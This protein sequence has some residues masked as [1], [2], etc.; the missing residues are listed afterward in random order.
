[1]L[2]PRRL[3]GRW[4]PRHQRAGRSKLCAALICRESTLTWHRVAERS[5]KRVAAL[6]SRMSKPV[7]QQDPCLRHVQ[8]FTSKWMRVRPQPRYILGARCAGAPRELITCG[9][10]Q[11]LRGAVGHELHG[12]SH[13]LPVAC[14]GPALHELRGTRIR[15]G[16]FIDAEVTYRTRLGLIR[17]SA[18]NPPSLQAVAGFRRAFLAG[19]RVA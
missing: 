11:T 17:Y 8:T 12:I 2:R 9:D 10:L 7:L 4:P 5:E 15:L 6:A 14:V 18:H 3:N 13:V 16:Q 19:S 1:L